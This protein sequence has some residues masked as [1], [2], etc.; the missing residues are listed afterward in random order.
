ME[1]KTKEKVSQ[2]HS[3]SG[4]TLTL[5]S[6]LRVCVVVVVYNL[7]C[8]YLLASFF[9]FFSTEPIPNATERGKLS[10]E[11]GLYLGCCTN[12]VPNCVPI[13]HN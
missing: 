4:I 8:L 6:H 5:V 2:T 7:V 10:Q 3:Y 11:V 13:L 9:Q 1:K 12:Y